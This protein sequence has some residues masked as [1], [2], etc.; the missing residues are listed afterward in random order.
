[1]LCGICLC[2]VAPEELPL[3]IGPVCGH[4]FH[5]D[6]C[7]LRSRT[8]GSCLMICSL[9]YSLCSVVQLLDHASLHTH[10]HTLTHS[11]SLVLVVMMRSKEFKTSR[12]IL[13]LIF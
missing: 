4:Q 2:E 11:L 6:D 12:S 7:W 1:M 3:G 8:P 9:G 5:K 13:M 10:N